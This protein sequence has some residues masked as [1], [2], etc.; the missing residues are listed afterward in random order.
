MHGWRPAI[1]A[2]DKSDGVFELSASG[3]LDEATLDGWKEHLALAENAHGPVLLDLLGVTFM[4]SR[5]L[6]ALLRTR[7]TVAATRRPFAV[8]CDPEGAVQRLFAVTGTVRLIQPYTELEAAQ[9]DLSS[10]SEF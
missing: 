2:T 7:E 4:D 5:C 10:G 6:A 8:V 9:Q 3:E 1:F